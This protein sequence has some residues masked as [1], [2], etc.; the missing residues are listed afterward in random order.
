MSTEVIVHF[1]SIIYFP[2][3]VETFGFGVVVCHL[4]KHLRGNSERSGPW[5]WDFNA[6]WVIVRF[7]F[8]H[9]NMW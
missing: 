2:F 6:S 8:M 9:G 4:D 5:L 3:A 1:P 7:S